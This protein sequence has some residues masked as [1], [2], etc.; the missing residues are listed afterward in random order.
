MTLRRLAWAK[1]NFLRT[2][3]KCSRFQQRRGRRV[4]TDV[5]GNDAWRPSENE[6]GVASPNAPVM[7]ALPAEQTLPVSHRPGRSTT[8]MT[9]ARDAP[10][11]LTMAAVSQARPLQHPAIASGASTTWGLR[12][13]FILAFRAPWRTR[14]AAPATYRKRPGSNPGIALQQPQYQLN[15]KATLRE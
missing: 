5:S 15:G 1:G 7:L 4:T 9:I 11:F 2:K 6:T 10:E 8:N 12:R 13:H 14:W 3:G